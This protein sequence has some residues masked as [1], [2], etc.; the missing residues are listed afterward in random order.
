MNAAEQVTSAAGET[1]ETAAE[2]THLKK[3]LGWMV[4]LV[5]RRDG[6]PKAG[7]AVAVAMDAHPREAG[8]RDSN[9]ERKGFVPNKL[10]SD[11][12]AGK[13]LEGP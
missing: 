4:L 6:R 10:A 8:W 7:G 2:T 11:S 12:I 5:V 13:A 1:V 3:V 9:G